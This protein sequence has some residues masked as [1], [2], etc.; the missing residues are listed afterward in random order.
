[1]GSRRSREGVVEV[2]VEGWPSWFGAL[3]GLQVLARLVELLF[4]EFLVIWEV[5]PDFA[6]WGLGLEDLLLE[7]G[8]EPQDLRHHLALHH[9]DE[10]CHKS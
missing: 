3:L 5:F 1:M 9:V 8:D 6:T 10:T 4:R 7:V 2:V